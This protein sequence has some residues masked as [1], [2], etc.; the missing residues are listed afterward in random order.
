MSL[1]GLLSVTIGV[2]N[3]AETGARARGSAVSPWNCRPAGVP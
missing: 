3:A 1:H 2:P